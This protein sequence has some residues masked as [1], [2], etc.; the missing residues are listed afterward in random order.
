MYS[1][2]YYV[3]QTYCIYTKGVPTLGEILELHVEC[4]LLGT[5]YLGGADFTT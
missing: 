2:I 1:A 4:V 3:I 5:P